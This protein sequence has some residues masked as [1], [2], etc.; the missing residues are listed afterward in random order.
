MHVPGVLYVNYL[1][2]LLMGGIVPFAQHTLVAKIIYVWRALPDCLLWVLKLIL[3][4]APDDIEV[5][6]R[7]NAEKAI[8]APE[9]GVAW[10]YAAF[11]IHISTA[12]LVAS[13]VSSSVCLESLAPVC[14]ETY[15]KSIAIQDHIRISTVYEGKKPIAMPVDLIDLRWKLFLALLAWCVFFHLW[16]RF[17]HLRVQ[18]SSSF[19]GHLLDTMASC[20]PL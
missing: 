8:E 11:I 20:Q 3:P 16:S 19:N 7:F 4:W 6:P 17:M 12:F 9:M 14:K 18:T 5:Y 2:G 1:M 13:V 10:D 15:C